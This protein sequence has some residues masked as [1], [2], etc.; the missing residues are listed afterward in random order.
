M[1]ES[2]EDE[3]DEEDKVDSSVDS[4]LRVTDV[5]DADTTLHEMNARL[6][7]GLGSAIHTEVP[8]SKFMVVDMGDGGDGG[9]RREGRE[10]G[11][12]VL[13]VAGSNVLKFY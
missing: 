12:E 10:L 8:G 4:C 6:E 2:Q 13:R 11:E 5:G 1:S 9:V 7:V 3:V